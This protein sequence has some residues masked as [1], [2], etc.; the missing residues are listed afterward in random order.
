[1]NQCK[2]LKTSSDT[3]FH[4]RG[5]FNAYKK[6]LEVN[7]WIAVSLIDKGFFI[8]ANELI[9][10]HSETISAQYGLLLFNFLKQTTFKRA[11]GKIY[12]SF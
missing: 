11:R 10:S 6:R 3:V 4:E 9:H 8:G 5:F 2:S 1:M 7:F 12:V